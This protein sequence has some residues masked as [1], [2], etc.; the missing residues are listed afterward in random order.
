MIEIIIIFGI[1]GAIIGGAAGAKRGKKT[2]RSAK[3][4]PKK[5]DTGPKISRNHKKEKRLTNINEVDIIVRLE[6]RGDTIYAYDLNGDRVFNIS[7]VSRKRAYKNKNYL[8]RKIY[9][10]GTVRW[11]DLSSEE[12]EKESTNENFI[13]SHLPKRNSETKS[14]KDKPT[15]PSKRNSSPRKRNKKK[16]NTNISKGTANSFIRELKKERAS[17]SKELRAKLIE[18][19][20]YRTSHSVDLLVGRH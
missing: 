9:K 20:R 2:N 8:G 15:K 3:K 14:A 17:Q 13:K 1:F 19:D 4:A 11:M 12:V 18:A 5:N 16:K 6:K 7:S 10:S